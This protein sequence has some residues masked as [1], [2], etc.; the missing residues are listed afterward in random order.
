MAADLTG[1]GIRNAKVYCAV[2][3]IFDI[4]QS[5]TGYPPAGKLGKRAGRAESLYVELIYLLNNS[6]GELV[7]VVVYAPDDGILQRQQ[8]AEP[9][10]LDGRLVGETTRR[11]YT[12]LAVLV[13]PDL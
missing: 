1:A 2:R 5:G 7:K 9:S 13:K 6:P 11:R 10:A 4:R 3:D 12:Q 8:P